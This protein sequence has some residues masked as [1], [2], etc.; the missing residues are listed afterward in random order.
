ML[1]DVKIIFSQ[2]TLQ[3]S[4]FKGLKRLLLS[5]FSGSV[6][7]GKNAAPPSVDETTNL[8]ADHTAIFENGVMIGSLPLVSLILNPEGHISNVAAF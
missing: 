7:K 8:T 2:T 1:F 4:Y 3:S 5:I 6:I